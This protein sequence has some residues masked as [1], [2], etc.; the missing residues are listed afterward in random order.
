MLCITSE[1]VTTHFP[2]GAQLGPIVARS[3]GDYT[4]ELTQFAVSTKSGSFVISGTYD[5]I[6]DFASDIAVQ[7]MSWPLLNKKTDWFD[8]DQQAIL[9]RM[10]QDAEGQ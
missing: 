7:L 1:G 10:V 3:A 9:E 2:F 8:S 6:S 5:E 4:R